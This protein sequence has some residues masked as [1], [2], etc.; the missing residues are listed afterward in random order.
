MKKYILITTALIV[1]VQFSFATLSIPVQISPSSGATN[2]YPNVQLDWSSVSG[3]ELYE[4][5]IG[6]DPTMTTYALYGAVS[7]YFTTSSLYFNTTYYWQVRATSSTPDSSDWSPVWSFTTGDNIYLTSPVDGAVNQYPTTLLD[8]ETFNGITM[9]EYEVDTVNTFDSPVMQTGS[10]G[11]NSYYYIYN[12]LFGETYY[13]RIRAMHCCDTTSWSP[14]WSFSTIDKLY[15]SSPSNGAVNQVTDVQLDWTGITGVTNYEYQIDTVNTFDSPLLQTISTGTNSYGN[16]SN[17]LFGQKY[18]WRVRA[19]HSADTS[20]WSDVWNFTTRDIIYLSSP[21]NGATNQVPNV[22]LD[23][24]GITGVTNYEYQLDTVITF[25]SPVF[26]SGLTGTTSYFNS[27]NLYFGKTYYWRV[28]AINLNDTSQWSD[29]WSFTTLNILA[30]VSPSDGATGQFPDVEIDWTGIT[31]ITNYEYQLDT[32]NTFNSGALQTGLSGT[33]SYAYAAAL[34]FNKIYY[35]RVRAIH[36]N[37]TTLWSNVWHFTTVSTLSNVS[38]ANGSINQ[39]PDVTIDWSYMSGCTYYDYEIDTTSGFNSPL[40]EYHSINTSSSQASLANLR[41]GKKY[42]WRVRARHANDTTE[43]STPWTFITADILTHTSPADGATN[44]MPDVTL[45]WSYMSGIIYYDYELDTTPMFNSSMY[46]YHTVSSASSQSATANLHFGYEY[47]WRVRAR[48]NYDTTQWS[49]PWKFYVSYGVTLVS[50]SDGAANVSVNQIIDWSYMSGITN[51]H[52]QYDTDPNFSAPVFYS[53]SNASSQANLNGLAYG[54]TYYWQV[55][56][57][58]NTDTS[59][60]TSPWHFTT[61][62]QITNPVVLVSP[63]DGTSGVNIPVTLSWQNYAGAVSYHYQLDTSMTFLNPVSGSTSNLSE[64]ISGLIYGE[65]YY[66]RVRANNGSGYSP[67]SAVWSFT[68]GDIGIPDLIAP[69]NG[70][71]NISVTSVLLDWTDV[72]S[73]TGYDYQY[74]EDIT[75]TTNVISNSTTASSATITGLNYSST[76]Y[77][78]VRAYDG[79]GYGQ[80]SNIWIFSTELTPL[81]Q[82]QLHVPLNG[83]SLQPVNNLFFDWYSV[84]SADEY[85]FEYTPDPGFTFGITTIASSDTFEIIS[86]LLYGQMYY[87]RV[88]AVELP[89]NYGP[90]SDIWSFTTESDPFGAPSLLLPVDGAVDQEYNNLLLDWSDVVNTVSYDYQYSTDSL[91]NIFQGTN[92]SVSQA[93][94]S[95]LQYNTKYYWRV[96]A[97]NGSAF[98][99]WSDTLS[100]TTKMYTNIDRTKDLSDFYIYPVPCEDKVFY[101]AKEGGIIEIIDVNGQIIYKNKSGVNIN[102]INLTEFTSGIY[103]IRFTSDKYSGVIKL[104]KK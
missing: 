44:Q 29:I 1:F 89:S 49:I 21:S 63:A 103:Y 65:T 46:S 40:Y 98:S 26:Q 16:T 38:P 100:F 30:L 57:A 28:R 81:N 94:V 32:V 64:N 59:D 77:W 6:T 35:W 47:Y 15:L 66:W 18:Y 31:G 70:A 53:I 19:M 68:I 56:V 33:T 3:A 93:Y 25:D 83:S 76:Y 8:W 37:D 48:H 104:L 82:V 97:Y 75:F 95:G 23:W 73:I 54:E 22:Q 43:W 62:Y 90:W 71:T 5:R 42:W 50:P 24:T 80:W 27:S 87:W 20:S 2:Q 12:L 36:N 14:V 61:L 7:S 17:L 34:Y 13:W 85:E 91:F 72:P 51:Y 74:S 67:W 45:D 60:W 41:F 99:D 52:Y 88:R 92:V 11:L 96:R 78:R 102:A 39:F 10:S 69:S 58:H 86:G 4:V 79:N 84:P 55:R 9:Y 101:Y